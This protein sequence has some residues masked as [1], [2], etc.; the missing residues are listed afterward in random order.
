MGC[1]RGLAGIGS[2]LLLAGCVG[3]AGCS[4]GDSNTAGPDGKMNWQTQ[5]VGL[6][7][8]AMWGSSGSNVFTVGTD[9][10]ILHYD[11]GHWIPMASGTDELLCGVWGNSG[12]SV[13]AVGNL[14][15]NDVWGSSS[16]DVFAVGPS[17]VVHYDGSDWTPM[18]APSAV[19]HDVWGSSGSDVFS[20]G[21]AGT[22]LHFNG[23]AWTEMASDTDRML[24]G[25][26]GSSGSDVFAVGE[27][28]TVV[29]YGP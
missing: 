9:G 18:S 29:H 22:I 23:R 27:N 12:G 3:L 17:G 14:N 4:G 28:A 24:S 11:G 2:K 15:A 20:V 26:W 25:L 13:F 21:E 19:L 8:R 16:S 10:V 6:N 7:T 1:L 5:H